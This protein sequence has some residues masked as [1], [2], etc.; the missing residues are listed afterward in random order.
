MSQASQRTDKARTRGSTAAPV[1]ALLPTPGD[2]EA[3]TP[4]TAREAAPH[5]VVTNSPERDIPCGDISTVRNSTLEKILSRLD[6]LDQLKLDVAELNARSGSF[7]DKY[8]AAIRAA[9]VLGAKHDRDMVHVM[10]L[11]EESREDRRIER[12]EHLITKSELTVSKELNK[13]MHTQLN[14]MEN[15][16]KGC[17]LRLDGVN[18]TDRDD[19]KRIVLDMATAMGVEGIAHGDISSAYRVGKIPANPQRTAHQKSRTILVTFTSIHKRN[20][21]YFART[22]LRNSD[23]YNR[24]FINDD[25]TYVTRKQRDDYKSVANIARADGVEVRLHGDGIVLNGRKHLNTEPHTL[26]EKYSLAAAKTVEMGGELYFASEHS[27][28]SNF[29]N[30]PIIEGDIVFTSA[31]HMYQAHKC[32]HAGDLDKARLVASAPTPLEAKRIA[33]SIHETPEWRARRDDVMI[34]V[35]GCKFDQNPKLAEMLINT[36][37]IPLNE[38]THNTYFGIGVPLHAREIREKSYRGANKLGLILVDKRASIMAAKN[39]N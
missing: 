25:V 32:R 21:F 26:P 37:D 13:R 33:D 8:A 11:L 31:E 23:R 2:K 28:L 36:G 7:D 27:F 10:N 5:H 29:F 15:R 24:V 34:R 14:E 3:G 18:E 38:A 9:E 6:T 17:N 20:N 22:K 12:R 39:G 19:P 4:P 30:S 35:V 1:P 16:M